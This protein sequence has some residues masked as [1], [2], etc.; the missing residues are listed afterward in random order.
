MIVSY[1]QGGMGNQMFQF[2]QG[3]ALAKKFRTGMALDVTNYVADTMREYSLDLWAGVYRRF[4]KVTNSIVDVKENG[5]PFNEHQLDEFQDNKVY[6][7]YWQT[8][9][10]FPGLERDLFQIFTPRQPLTATGRDT[11]RDIINAG[12]RSIFLTIR[13]TDYVGNNFH[14]ELPAEYYIGAINKI[15]EKEIISR[16]HIFIFSDDTSFASQFAATYL[17]QHEC[18]VAGN[19]DRTVKGHLGRE[20]EELFLMR[21]CSHAVMANST[22]SWWGA[23][24]GDHNPALTG[25]RTVVCPKQWFGPGSNENPVDIPRPNWIQL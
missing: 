25:L 4:D 20:D 19:W 24:M 6:R 1:I 8:E 7:G 10:Y 16:P 22:Y 3:Y 17:G 12:R 21:S 9:K 5:M 14:G 2:A 13:R 23:Y 15:M 18:T 11:Y